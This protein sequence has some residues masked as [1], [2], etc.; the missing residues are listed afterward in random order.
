MPLPAQVAVRLQELIE[1]GGLP[2][3]AR[4]QSEVT[5]AE[6]PGISRPTVRRAMQHLVDRGLV[7]RRPG[8][9][10]RGGD[11]VGAP[12]RGADQPV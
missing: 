1:T 4:I 12:A 3:G 6:R 2:I 10:T 5:L 9:G 11:A 8:A 7:V